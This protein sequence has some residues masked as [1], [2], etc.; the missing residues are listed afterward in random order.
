LE[1]AFVPLLT[2]LEKRAQFLSS[3]VASPRIYK[4]AEFQALESAARSNCF[5]EAARLQQEQK[6]ASLRSSAPG[7][8]SSSRSL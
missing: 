7:D 3:V 4:T 1:Y 5:N 2:Y 6:A 8:V